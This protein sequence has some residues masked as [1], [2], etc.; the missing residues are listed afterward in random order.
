LLDFFGVEMLTRSTIIV[1]TSL[2]SVFYQILI[3][4]SAMLL[5]SALLT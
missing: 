4:S 2:H 5:E 3:G 1:T